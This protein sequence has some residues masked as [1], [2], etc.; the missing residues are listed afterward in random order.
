LRRNLIA[1]MG[2]DGA[3]KSTQAFLLREKL[4]RKKFKTVIIHDELPQLV[5]R[6]LQLVS[7]RH[8]KRRKDDIAANELPKV[9][10]SFSLRNLLLIFL[11]IFNE[12]LMLA[13]ILNN[14]KKSDVIILDRWFPDS[15][16]SVA[17]HNM[18]YIPL[19]KN[20]LLM[21]GKITRLIIK[22]T[23]TLIFVVL[24]KVDPSIA[25]MRRPEHSFLRQKIVNNVIDYFTRIIVEKNNWSFLAIDS[26][27][28]SVLKVHVMILE[29]LRRH[30][31]FGAFAH[32]YK[33]GVT[34]TGEKQ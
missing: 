13:R 27:D 23:K 4:K 1:L 22:L 31:I 30:L 9:T 14:L 6:A 32:T 34:I 24:L 26:T 16:A 8:H 10:H 20:T 15:L 5:V 2:V 17:Y 12:I 29:A 25:H 11:Y 19:I 3:G 18:V 28:A 7:Q 21:I 33:H